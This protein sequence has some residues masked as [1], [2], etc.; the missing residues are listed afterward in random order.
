MMSQARKNFHLLCPFPLNILAMPLQWESSY[1]LMHV[2]NWMMRHLAVTP[3]M[4]GI[5]RALG[6]NRIVSAL[7]IYMYMCDYEPHAWSYMHVAAF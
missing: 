7:L 1:T 4:L 2:T 3:L 5:Y 6:G